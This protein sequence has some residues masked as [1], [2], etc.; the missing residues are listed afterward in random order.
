MNHIHRLLTAVLALV[1]IV[2]SPLLAQ[3]EPAK[4]SPPTWQQ[5]GPLLDEYCTHCHGGEG[6]TRGLDLGT[7]AGVKK[8]SRDGE[9]IETDEP[10]ESELVLRLRGK[11]E[12]RMPLDGPPY[13]TSEQIALVVAWIEA[14][15]P[16]GSAPEKPAKPDGPAKPGEPEKPEKPE[17][18]GASKP[19]KGRKPPGPNDPV[20]WSHVAPIFAKRCVKCHKNGGIRGKAP[21]GLELISLERVLRGGERVAL[22]PGNASASPIVRHVRGIASPRMPLDGPP[23]LSN[24]EIALIERWVRGGALDSSGN[25][26]PV[27]VGREVRYRGRLTGIWQIDGID[28]IVD[29]G[30]RI[31]KKKRPRVGEEAEVRGVIL[32][33]GRIR[34]TRLRRR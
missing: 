15:L 32:G 26:S 5:I 12:P 21:E 14:G 9:V 23:Y 7:L 29:G 22:I 24:G 30:T 28:V 6:P 3:D 27:P 1:P 19:P 25:P 34:A 33:D 10:E 4:K 2:S 20:T 16:E 31:D 8:G 11:S 17:K 18:P 13:L